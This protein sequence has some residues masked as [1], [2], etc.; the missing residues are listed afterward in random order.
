MKSL[1]TSLCDDNP[2]RTTAQMFFDGRNDV[3]SAFE[4]GILSLF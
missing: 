3:I 2:Q 4:K 1:M